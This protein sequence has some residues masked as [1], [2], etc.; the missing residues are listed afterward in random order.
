MKVLFLLPLLAACATTPRV[1]EPVTVIQKVSV[2]VS[3]PCVPSN[4]DSTRPDYVDGDTVLRAASIPERLQLLWA[5]RAQRIAR[6]RENETVIAG[7]PR[8]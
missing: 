1:A 5:G 2:P 7:C 6:E 3:V 8:G 4:Y